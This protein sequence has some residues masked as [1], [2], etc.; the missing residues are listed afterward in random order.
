[1]GAVGYKADLLR[2]HPIFGQATVQGAPWGPKTMVILKGAKIHRLN[3]GGRIR[4]LSSAQLSAPNGWEYF[5]RAAQWRVARLCQFSATFRLRT[6]K[7]LPSGMTYW[8]E[9]KKLRGRSYLCL[10]GGF[11]KSSNCQSVDGERSDDR[12]AHCRGYPEGR[13][14]RARDEDGCV[15]LQKAATVI[16]RRCRMFARNYAD[17]PAPGAL[18][19][20]AAVEAGA[21][22]N[23]TLR[24][25]WRTQEVRCKSNGRYT[26][27]GNPSCAD[28]GRLLRCLFN[29][30]FTG[31]DRNLVLR[32][33]PGRGSFH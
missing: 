11:R 31:P 22:V 10:A 19:A 14:G 28:S 9:R 12:G 5:G 16:A 21:R 4:H 13:R 30:I 33:D 7:K 18:E 6:A 23:A 2:A 3:L 8:K 29:R 32:T 1:M 25:I 15:Y 27:R 24:R 17:T 26:A 20:G